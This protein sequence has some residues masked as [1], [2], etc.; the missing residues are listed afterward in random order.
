[1][2]TNSQEQSLQPNID[3]AERTR[4][5][6]AGSVGQFVEW[7]DF[8]IYAYSAPI[9]AVLFFPQGNATAG[10]IGTFAIFGVS[11][12]VRPLGGI[13][14]GNLGD[15]IG[16]RATLS[17]VILL[18]GGATGV[19]G[20]LPTYGQIG[21]LAPILLL[22]C[23]LTQGFS[24]GGEATGALSYVME[25]APD[26]R[27][28]LWVT[29]VVAFS[30][31]PAILGAL[32]VLAST[33]TLSDSA[34]ASWGWRIPFLVGALMSVVG[35]YIRLRMEETPAF[36]TVQSEGQVR[37]IPAL[38]AVRSRLK[39]MGFV[40]ALTSLQG[41]TTY[42]L[43]AYFISYLTVT[44]GLDETTALLSNIPAAAVFAIVMI[45]C[46][47]LGDRVGRKR[48]LAAGGLGLA[49]FSI[50]AY[51]IAGIGG[52]GYAM[53][54][55]VLLAIAA[56][57]FAGGSFITVLEL[58]PADMRYSGTA[59]PYNIGYAVFGGTAPLVGT[60]LVSQTGNNI[61]PA[62]YF[63]VVALVALVVIAVV[64]E[65]RESSLIRDG[66]GSQAARSSG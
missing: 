3:Y 60:F 52:L 9:L 16:R 38:D 44:I 40:F 59:I 33:A 10:L 35:L 14:F 49:L 58:F 43:L 66:N 13:F 36:R 8:S 32:I 57:V 54:G 12:F 25:Y 53:A 42:T 15:K 18:M 39:E 50:P 65:T 51:F 11:F 29:I 24:A 26:N 64:P 61:A 62:I 55:Q 48:L 27:R 34:Y 56:G 5:L 23:R 7:F 20:L 30:V 46:G 63:A 45:L 19:I 21:L 22:V 1:M 31:V 41:L 17:T 2:E 47:L 28:G 37:Q 4:V 6:T